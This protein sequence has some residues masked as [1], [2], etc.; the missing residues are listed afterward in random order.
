MDNLLRKEKNSHKVLRTRLKN[1]W[2]FA[3]R[4]TLPKWSI[5]RSAHLIEPV[6][7][8]SVKCGRTITA[9]WGWDRPKKEQIDRHTDEAVVNGRRQL[10]STFVLIHILQKQTFKSTTHPVAFKE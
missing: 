9:L 5:H 2:M 1:A 4:S 7:H 3:C 10:G 8:A 6:D